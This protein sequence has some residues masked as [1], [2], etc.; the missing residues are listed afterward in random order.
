[1]RQH[2]STKLFG[3]QKAPRQRA[4]RSAR[5]AFEQVERR[6]LLSYTITLNSIATTDG[7]ASF[8]VTYHFSGTFAGATPS[9]PDLVLYWAGANSLQSAILDTDPKYPIT[10]G[11]AASGR[12]NDAVKTNGDDLSADPITVNIPV[13]KQRPSGAS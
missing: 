11:E 1:M 4:V 6:L 9:Q 3:S 13:L 8:N 2:W 7:G 12:S 5:P 10:G